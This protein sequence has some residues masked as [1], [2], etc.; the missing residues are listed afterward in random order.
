[1][2]EALISCSKE[3]GCMGVQGYCTTNVKQNRLEGWHFKQTDHQWDREDLTADNQEN[4]MGGPDMRAQSILN[5]FNLRQRG[6]GSVIL[7][8]VQHN[9]RCGQIE[10]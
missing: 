6:F 5:F 7:K 8:Y 9:R 3:V 4:G 2:R 1:M 10:E